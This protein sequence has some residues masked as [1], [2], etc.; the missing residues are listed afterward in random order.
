MDTLLA[1]KVLVGTTIQ[2]PQSTE[3]SLPVL[4][5]C[6]SHLAACTPAAKVSTPAAHV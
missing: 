4:L 5:V 3:I 6:I 2:Q 1:W